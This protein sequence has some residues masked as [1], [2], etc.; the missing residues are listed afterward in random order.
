MI[1]TLYP[2]DAPWHVSNFKFRADKGFY[3]GSKISIVHPGYIVQ[4]GAPVTFEASRPY[5]LPPE[6][7]NKP[8]TRGTL[9]MARRQDII[10]AERNSDSAQFH[11]L[12]GSGP[13]MDGLYTSFG[14]LRDGDELLDLLEAGDRIERITVYISKAP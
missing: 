2:D 12:L 6:F 10:N 4:G 9:G 3:N 8:H 11:I 1:F 7:T 5:S 14:Q 13:H